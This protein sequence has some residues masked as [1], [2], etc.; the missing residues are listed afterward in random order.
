MRTHALR[1]YGKNDLRLES[2]ELPA[3]GE[4][5]ILAT[6]VSNSICMS[7]HKAA[8]QGPDHKRV[9]KDIARNPI[10]IGHEFSGTILQTG[11]KYAH[12]FKPGQNY[13]IQPALSYPGRVA[14]APGYS[15]PYT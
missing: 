5:E 7:D 10:I 14:E 12:K 8:E 4:D 6:V 11:Q 15:F 13:G 1:L 9:P 2:F 3:I